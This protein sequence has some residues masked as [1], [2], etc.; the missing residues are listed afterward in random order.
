MKNVKEK[1]PQVGQRIQITSSWSNELP[2]GTEGKIVNMGKR[3]N[4]IRFYDVLW[5][6]GIESYVYDALYWNH[7]E[8]IETKEKQ[9][10]TD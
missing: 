7:T 10:I 8:V 5:D 3:P 2:S 9:E 6:N 1:V 4:G